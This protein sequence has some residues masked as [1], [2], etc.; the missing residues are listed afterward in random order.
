MRDTTA[1]RTGLG[2]ALIA[3]PLAIFGILYAVPSW[4]RA[5]MAPSFHFYVV[6]LTALA[7]AI[8]CGVV[9]ASASTL[10]ETRLLFLGLAFFSIAGIFAVHGLATPG[11]ILDEFYPSVPIS[12]WLSA[13][14][15]GAFAAAS[16]VTLPPKL[17]RALARNGNVIFATAAVLIGAY[18]Y[19]SLRVDDWLNWV[20]IDNR[21]LQLTL[22]F[23]SGALIAF[24]AWRYYQAFVF[25]RLPS[26]IVMVA[27][28][29]LLLEVQVIILWGQVWYL[30]WWIYHALYGVALLVLFT[31]WA[32]EVR[33][34]GTLRAIADAL[35]MRDALAQLNRGLESPIVDLVD[36]VEAKDAET[37]GHVRR[38]SEHA[39]GI[40]RKLGLSQA[41]LRQLVL[42]AEM[43]DVGKISIPSSI[44]SKPGPLNDAEYGLLKTHTVRGHEIA[45]K[46]Q[47]LRPLA[48]VV[49][50]HHEHYDGKG[51]PDGLSGDDIPL[52]SRIVSVAD[53]YDA[54]TSK[55][56][57]RDPRSPGEALAEIKRVRGTQLDPR[58]VDAFI[59]VLQESGSHDGPH[60]GR[61]QHEHAA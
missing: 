40:G 26:Q 47:A 45:Q 59:T 37:F 4:D 31:G 9:I 53:T 13:A 38:V 58:C 14:L 61:D 5:I 46:V 7:A 29:L 30:S 55:R 16:V 36:A 10:R 21:N 2:G 48:G 20:P 6:G 1:L 54:I 52:L 15:G 12:A 34:S 8:A 19:L 49:R 56:P 60:A 39:L 35:S 43:H 32:L 23:T 25:A 28:L 18:I 22:G 42:A 57:Y 41:E 33:R 11:F 24:A 3:A 17:D 27:T 51:Y 44:L 50:H